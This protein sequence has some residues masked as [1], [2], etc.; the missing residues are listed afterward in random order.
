[1]IFFNRN[2]GVFGVNRRY[3]T[4]AYFGS[5]T[6]ICV[7]FVG[8]VDLLL[9]GVRVPIPGNHRGSWS[10]T[11]QGR[12]RTV[13]GVV[14]SH[15]T[16]RLWV[17]SRSLSRSVHRKRVIHRGKAPA[18]MRQNLWTQC[19]LPLTIYLFLQPKL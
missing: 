15:R 1:M 11:R 2:Q 7:L 4:I 10:G 5:H 12:G 6:A 3:F 14:H 19:R 13:A 9:R 17:Y 16:N 18:W 8:H